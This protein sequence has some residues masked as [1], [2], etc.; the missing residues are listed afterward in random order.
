MTLHPSPA[1]A[2]AEHLHGGDPGFQ[3]RAA[4]TTAEQPM[5]HSALACELGCP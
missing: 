2:C 5:G 1:F 3:C 4:T